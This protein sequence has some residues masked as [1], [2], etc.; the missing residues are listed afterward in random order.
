M[1]FEIIGKIGEVATSASGRSIRE[2]RRLWKVYGKG[3]WHKK[4]GLVNVKLGDGTIYKAEIA[5]L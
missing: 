2:R 4:K 5:L 3:R 1:F